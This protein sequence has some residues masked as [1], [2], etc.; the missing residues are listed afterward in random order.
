MEATRTVILFVEHIVVGI[1]FKQLFDLLVK[2]GDRF[3]QAPH[4]A[5][6]GLHHQGRG[7]G[8]SGVPRQRLGLV[9]F[10]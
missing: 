9:N 10:F 4:L 8:D 2:L 1:L 6:Q 7:L 5:H 3:D